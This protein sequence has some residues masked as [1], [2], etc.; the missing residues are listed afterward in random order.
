MVCLFSPHINGET[1]D[2]GISKT[3]GL[4]FLG[5]LL[6]LCNFAV[7]GKAVFKSGTWRW[8]K[9]ALWTFLGIWAL[10]V[11]ALQVILNSNVLTRMANRVT[12]EYVDGTVTFSGIKASMFRSFPNL[13][14]TV[15]DFS[16]TYPHDRFAAY[17]SLE[18]PGSYLLGAGRGEMSDTLAHFRKL[19]VSVNYL[20][21]IAGRIRI[22]HAILDHPRIFAHQYD[23]TS[24]NWNIFGDVS[25][26]E[27]SDTSSSSA[28]PPVSIGKVSLDGR[29]FVVY[30]NPSDT[31]FGCI[32]LKSLSAKGHYDAR[33]GKI[34]K[35]NLTLDSL[36]VAG[37]LPADTVALGLERLGVKERNGH[38]DVNLKS[39]L[40]LGL[41]SSG[42]MAIPVEI[43]GDIFPELDKKAVSV[44]NLRASV[45]AI[46]L[47]AN[48]KAD[49]SRKNIH[50]KATADIDKASVNGLVEHFGDNFPVLKKLRTDALLTVNASCDG[51]YDKSSG[52]LPPLSVRIQVPDSKIGWEGI[53]GD[54]RFDLD[55]TARSEDGKLSAEVPDFCFNVNGMKISVNGS[56]EDLL[57]GDP[58]FD[59]SSDIHVV[60]D[61]LASY[62]PDSLGISVHGNLEGIVEGG[63]KLSQLDPYNF[64]GIELE[65]LLESKNIMV[66]V[67]KDSI[68][69][70]I[71]HTDISLGEFSH[72]EEDQNSHEEHGHHHAGLS[73][74]VDS[75]FT[76][77]G[78][79]TFIRGTGIC[80]SAHNSEELMSGRH[81]RHPIHGHFD[82]TSLG[83]MDIDSCFVGVLGSANTFKLSQNPIS[84]HTV[85]FMNISS[86]NKR[87]TVREGVNRISVCDAGFSVAAHPN[88]IE[89]QARRKHL[90]DSLQRVYPGVKRDSL[91]R[92][93]FARKAGAILPDYLSEKDFEKSDIK[94]Q[95]GESVANYVRNWDIS[96]EI[97]VDE[98]LVISPYYPL[99]NRLTGF[100]GRFT[101]NRIDLDKLS[102]KSGSSDISVTGHLSGLKRFLASGRGKLNLD[103]GI[104]SDTL[105]VNEALI[106]FNSG[107]S[108]SPPTH[109]TAL[110]V[111]DDD[112][113]LD[114]VRELTTADTTVS[115]ALIVLPSN[116]D[117]KVS[118]Q[119]GTI[120]YSKL[121]TTW[122]SSDLEMKERCLQATNTL[123]TTNMG[124]VYLEGFYSTK[125]KKDLK[126]GFDLN[127]VGITA[128]K[129]VELFP[130]VD[131]IVPMLK[132]FS[133]LL[134]C[135]IAATAEI[136]TS[137][138]IILPS[139]SGVIT[140]DGRNLSLTE[141]E[142]LNKLRRTL[143]FKD[144]DSSHVESLSIRGIIK[145]NQL[146]IFP[147][148]LNV[149]RYSI[150]A[151]GLQRFDQKFKYHLSAL[152]SPVPFKFGIN[153]DG[154][155][156]DWHWKL[157][158]TK[159]KS[160][161]IPLFDK[162]VDG[163]RI[164]LVNAIHS[165]FEK[166]VEQ[167]LKQTERSQEAIE[168]KKKELDYSASLTEDLSAEEKKTLQVLES[169]T[170]PAQ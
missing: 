139:L 64:S 147:F 40:F 95:I 91:F 146:E 5:N 73:V 11:T 30:T 79:S 145:D 52:S 56:A 61:S 159:Y 54:G 37:R 80:L 166:G 60:L 158:K 82:I 109:N 101:N 140:V 24:A 136:D 23:S 89:R 115:A 110:S 72:A 122:V 112:A 70:Y 28:L 116:L 3:F 71:G 49:F 78:A 22:R 162:Q 164:N 133:G 151:S 132:A 81:G 17:D 111:I 157:G 8:L 25:V 130:A 165:I 141:S 107:K 154:S 94:I 14:V 38:F 97:N 34:E 62:L 39:S 57:G 118:L 75:L 99:D 163:L 21:A 156:E 29:P 102:V 160:R 13:N 42:R 36:F 44:E 85:P 143:M 1:Y 33:E 113:Y 168:T 128:E 47:Y 103:L 108:F 7:M 125:T 6:F 84:G 124:D 45:A 68:F 31:V 117:A 105:D 152:K 169:V 137:M 129:V 18:V 138:N 153:L 131:S 142:D 51:F 41:K 4:P 43:E 58:R 149:D 106:A 121:E 96:G 65:G 48:G 15:D 88:S 19:S 126:A 150:A 119:A 104:S 69:A 32:F 20:A 90:L 100:K 63:F 86:R 2:G 76:E 161:N 74:T 87:I 35:V 59:I 83:M 93:A 55:I 98:G 148:I 26:K 10:V 77:Y 66:S 120:R 9:P 170:G 27:D 50:I 167:A 127:M 46:G 155:F 67:P 134:D 114:S 144:R 92:K 12:D 135:E 16:I 53:D 123:A